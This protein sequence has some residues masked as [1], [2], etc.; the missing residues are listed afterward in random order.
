MG[1]SHSALFAHGG[2][3][4]GTVKATFG[5]GSSVMGLVA[6]P[7]DLAAGLCLTIGWM[8]DRPAFAAEGNIR[9]TGATLRWMAGVLGLEVGALAEL[10]ARSS[11]D[12]AVV[13]PGFNG[14][15]APWWD[16]GAVGLISNCTLGTGPGS[17]ARAALESIPQQVCDVIDA[18]DRSVGRVRE[19]YADG[20][21]TRNATLMQL[22]AD[23]AARPVLAS[24]TAELSALGVAHLAG[25][26]AGLWTQAGL[27]A[28]ARSRTPYRPAMEQAERALHRERWAQ[29]VARSRG[30]PAVHGA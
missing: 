23:L 19:I 21:P 22:Q 17:L 27:A 7:G 2:F 10:A 30:L 12:G 6:T 26:G 28:M 24:S 14:L 1:D 16:R 15:G 3:E 29:A 18:V 9:A 13:V 4:P 25:I 8:T 20:G 11:S 5:T